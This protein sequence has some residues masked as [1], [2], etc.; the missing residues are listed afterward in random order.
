MSLIFKDKTFKLGQTL[1]CFRHQ[2][3]WFPFRMEQQN[4][5]GGERAR[6]PQEDAERHQDIQEMVSRRMLACLKSILETSGFVHAFIAQP[7]NP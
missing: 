2:A 6:A 1:C 4:L 5:R 7:E 3:G